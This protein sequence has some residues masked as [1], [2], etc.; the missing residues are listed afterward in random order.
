MDDIRDCMPLMELMLPR[1]EDP[2]AEELFRQLYQ[3]TEQHGESRRQAED[4]QICIETSLQCLPGPR[5][6]LWK[7]KPL[8]DRWEAP[9]SYVHKRKWWRPSAVLVPSP[10]VLQTITEQPERRDD[11][12]TMLPNENAVNNC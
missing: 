11:A 3:V 4:M 9:P 7:D 2:E 12:E 8:P 1:P 5:N 6:R 10:A